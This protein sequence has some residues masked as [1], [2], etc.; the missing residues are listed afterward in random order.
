M[1]PRRSLRIPPCCPGSQPPATI[2]RQRAGLE[3]DRPVPDQWRIRF[4]HRHFLRTEIVH[5]EA[6]EPSAIGQPIMDKVHR[7]TALGL[8]RQRQRDSGDDRSRLPR[9]AAQREAFLSTNAL[10]LLVIHPPAF[11]PQPHTEPGGTHNVDCSPQSL[12]SSPEVR[13][14]PVA[15]CGTAACSDPGPLTGTPAAG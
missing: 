4:N 10:D 9:S 2:V 11:P 8:A 1:P 13:C 6:L 3:C 5:R 7:I 15:D 12:E 14:R